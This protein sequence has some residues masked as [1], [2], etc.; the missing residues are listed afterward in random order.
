MQKLSG[1]NP[2]I[3]KMLKK[4][5]L[6]FCFYFRLATSWYTRGKMNSSFLYIFQSNKEESVVIIETVELIAMQRFSLEIVTAYL[7][8]VH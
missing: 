1:A 6:N 2:P 3:L 5:M 8:F 4:K 7:R